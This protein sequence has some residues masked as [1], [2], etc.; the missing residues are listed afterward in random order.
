[1]NYEQDFLLLGGKILTKGEWVTNERTGVRCKTIIGHTLVY[2]DEVPLLTTKQSFPVS[3]IAEIIGYLR[4]YTNAQQF[5][6]IGTKSWWVNSEETEAW[7]ANPLRKGKGDLG[8]VYGAVARDFGGI[9][10][11]YKVY[12]DLRKGID[13][14]GETI[15][16]WKPDEFDKGCLRPCMRQH[17]FSILG[18]KLYMESESRS[19]DY[20]CGLNFNSIQCYFLLKLMC[21]L[22]GYKFG[23]VRHNLINCHIYEPHIEGVREQLSRHPTKLEAT[24]D[25][26]GWVEA[27]QDVTEEHIHAREYFTLKGYDKTSHQG[28]IYFELIA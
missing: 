2:G 1:M 14:R 7:L 20:G 24:L 12:D 19:V 4:G 11:V 16:F 21:H 5:E 8:R 26:K 27:M 23:Q 15:T 17:T 22:T 25:I 28:K 10:L 9:D 6:D 13:D 18:D 3:A